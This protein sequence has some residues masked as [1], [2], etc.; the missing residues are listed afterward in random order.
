MTAATPDC[1]PARVFLGLGSNLGDRVEHLATALQRIRELG[2]VRA[3]SGVYE[4]A[5]EGFIDQPPFL[6]LVA[7][8]ETVLEPV[9]L[10]EATRGIERARGRVR[11]FRNAP[12]TLDI[13]VLL[14]GRRVVEAEGL[15]IPHPRMETRVFV[16]VPLLEIA[17]EA[18][19]PLTG[20]PYAEALVE[21]T[22]GQTAGSVS[23]AAGRG[24]VA[25]LTYAG[26]RRVIDGEELLDE[27]IG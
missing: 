18:A 15:T 25:G 24:E 14:F 12:R 13:D 20:R 3:V 17:P 1:A 9:E 8:L 21:L 5:P 26:A 2:E 19:D 27:R 6:N 10:L 11:S 23:G 16:L 4:T 22:A 7:E